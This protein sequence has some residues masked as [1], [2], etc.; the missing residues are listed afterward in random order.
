[1]SQTWRASAWPSSTPLAEQ[2][3]LP[4]VPE[5]TAEWVWTDDTGE[6]ADV[7]AFVHETVMKAEV[8]HALAPTFGTIIDCTVGGGGHTE[9]ILEAAPAVN[10]I[11]LDRDDVALEASRARLARFG[12]RVRF[13]KSPFGRV[14]EVIAALGIAPG[15]IRGLCADLGVSSPQ[16]DDP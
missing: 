12:D 6:E 15:T 5:P 3:A 7:N 16:L 13:V 10:V 14:A 9:A 2:L 8:V 11:A 1:M 4:G